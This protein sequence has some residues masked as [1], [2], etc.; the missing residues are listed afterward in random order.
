MAYQFTDQETGQTKIG[1]RP[2]YHE[3]AMGEAIDA[4]LHGEIE[5]WDPEE[6]GGEL[7]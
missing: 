6:T 5:E 4:R 2:S 7:P 1:G 3:R